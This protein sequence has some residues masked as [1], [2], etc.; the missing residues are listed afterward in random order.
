MYSIAYEG[1]LRLEGGSHSHK[2]SIQREWNI[3]VDYFTSSALPS[4]LQLN[5][6]ACGLAMPFTKTDLHFF[7]LLSPIY[8]TLSI[9][10]AMSPSTPFA[11]QQ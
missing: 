2:I 5:I 1:A 6:I 3:I 9:S 11:A 4:S 7:A 8:L 10:Q